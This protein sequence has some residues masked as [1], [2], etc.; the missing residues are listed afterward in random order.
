MPPEIRDLIWTQTILQIP[1]RTVE[2]RAGFDEPVEG[3][4]RME[5]NAY[6]TDALIPSILHVCSRSR[7]LAMRRWTLSFTAGENQVRPKTWFDF[8][9]DTL[10]FL[11]FDG[12][13]GF[14]DQRGRL[15]IDAK[16]ELENFVE[17]IALQEREKVKNV[18]FSLR[19]IIWGGYLSKGDGEEIARA[20]RGVFPGV[21]RLLPVCNVGVGGFGKRMELVDSQRGMEDWQ[22]NRTDEIKAT[23]VKEGWD[24]DIEL[25]DWASAEFALLSG[26]LEEWIQKEEYQ[27]AFGYAQLQKLLNERVIKEGFNRNRFAKAFEECA[28][29]FGRWDKVE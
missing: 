20:I 19:G 28:L 2:L 10:L 4:R 12:E 26:W 3:T 5:W 13:F 6:T 9:G 22:I 24:I 1:P 15:H 11:E 21:R 25:V 7:E 18:A 23:L 14:D 8:E 27:V 29:R 16:A 17:D